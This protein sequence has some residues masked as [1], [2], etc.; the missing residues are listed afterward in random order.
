MPH[1]AQSLLHTNRVPLILA[2]LGACLSVAAIWVSRTEDMVALLLVALALVFALSSRVALRNV[3][4]RAPMYVPSQS[5]NANCEHL[6]DA[7]PMPPVVSIGRTA[8]VTR[9]SI[10]RLGVLISSAFAGFVSVVIG[11]VI[12][13]EN[14]LFSW[15]LAILIVVISTIAAGASFFVMFRIVSC[16]SVAGVIALMSVSAAIGCTI[17]MCVSVIV[18]GSLYSFKLSLLDTLISISASALVGAGGVA[19]FMYYMTDLR[20]LIRFWSMNPTLTDGASDDKVG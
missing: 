9:R 20:E 13:F 3:Q 19:A 16:R 8:S 2:L 11:L 12:A 10:T 15:L 6:G 14:T 17:G 18:E 4:R 1:K 7:I 5:A